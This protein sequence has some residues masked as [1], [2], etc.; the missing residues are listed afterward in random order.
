V[1]K[2]DLT[3]QLEEIF[4]NVNNLVKFAEAKNVALLTL[5]AAAIFGL[6]RLFTWFKPEA[7]WALI[8]LGAAVIMLFVSLI[9]CL[10][11]F[12]ARVRVSR[13]LFAKP[14]GQPGNVY[15][16][17]HIADMQEDCFL[18][19]VGDAMGYRGD[20]RKLHRDLANQIVINSRIARKKYMLFNAALWVTM[21]TIATPIGAYVFYRMFYEETL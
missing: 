15:F 9:L 13:Y 11:S 14:V 2:D 17:N 21:A 4:E 19:A 16:F 20:V 18:A 1:A 5:D 6:L 10:S 8:A 12:F 7:S 3:E